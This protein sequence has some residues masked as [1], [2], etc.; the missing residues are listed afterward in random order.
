MEDFT[1]Q[2][3]PEGKERWV[4]LKYLDSNKASKF[5]RLNSPF[6]NNDD[7]GI[8]VVSIGV[9]DEYT[10]QIDMLLEI[11][12]ELSIDYEIVASGLI[13]K[14]QSMIKDKIEKLLDEII[15]SK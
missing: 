9:T 14:I 1:K 5:I 7:K 6:F 11:E 4:K 15:I 8:E 10:P 13:P 3:F 2:I 12:K